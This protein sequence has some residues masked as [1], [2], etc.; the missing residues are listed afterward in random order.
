ML[1]RAVPI[2]GQLTPCTCERQP[3]HYLC[4]GKNLHF[5]ECAPCGVTTRKYA[6]FQLAADEWEAGHRIEELKA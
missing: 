3:K 2:E 4:L 5:L 1:Q 6:S